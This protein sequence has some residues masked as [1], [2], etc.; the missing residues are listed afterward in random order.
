MDPGPDVEAHVRAVSSLVADA[1]RV[2]IVLTHGHSD[3][4]GAAARLA[5]ATG[6]ERVGAGPVQRVLGDGESVPTDVGELVAVAT[7]G[8]AQ[9]HLCFHWPSRAALFA[10]DLILG[11]GDTTLVAGYPGCVADYLSS[12][13]RLRTLA[14]RRIYPA[15][16][17]P[18]DDVDARLARF[19]AHRRARIAQVNAVLEEHPSATRVEILERVYGG[20]VPPALHPAA[21]ESLGA[22]LDYLG[23]AARA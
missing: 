8:H 14:L 10:G 16:G 9:E 20:T 23:E 1:D 11:Q 17:D 4:A 6:A 3:H 18:I 22:L 19:E 12:L 13:E 2:V 7:P 5:A 15:H 21:L